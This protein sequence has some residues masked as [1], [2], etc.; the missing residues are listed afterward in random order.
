MLRLGEPKQIA[1]AGLVVHRHMQIAARD[2]H[3]AMPS[4]V[5]NLGQ[6]A[7]AGRGVSKGN[8]NASFLIDGVI[9]W[10]IV[11]TIELGKN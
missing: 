3:V 4:G 9:F 2:A 8:A 10:Q 11:R 5:P 6:R 7:S 1:H